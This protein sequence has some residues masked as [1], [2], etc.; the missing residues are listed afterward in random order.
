MILFKCACGAGYSVDDDMAGQQATCASCGT[1]MSTPDCSDADLLL[2]YKE[3][4]D[5]AGV[6]MSREQVQA[7]VAAGVFDG[8]EQTMQNDAWVPI[9]TVLGQ[10]VP[11]PV[12][13]PVPETVENV[14]P[15]PSVPSPSLTED[16]TAPAWARSTEGQPVVA[17]PDKDDEH[18]DKPK[19]SLRR[20]TT[21]KDD[22]AAPDSGPEI[23]PGDSPVADTGP[24]PANDT[25][26]EE[27]K[28]H[29]PLF[30][31]IQI[32]I[33]LLILFVGYKYGFGPLISHAR[34]RSTL[35]VVQN[36]ENTEYQAKLGWRRLKQQL[37]ANAVCK[38]DLAVGMSETHTLTL[39]PQ[40]GPNGGEATAEVV[41]VRV[42]LRPNCQILVNVRQKGNYAIYRPESVAKENAR[43]AALKLN[44]EI[45]KGKRPRSTRAA[46][47]RLQE[48]G[49]KAVE[50]FSNDLLFDG[51]KY[52][53]FRMYGMMRKANDKEDTS[54]PLLVSAEPYT[55]KGDGCQLNYYHHDP[56]HVTG[57]L[58]LPGGELTLGDDMK[59]TIPAN[60]NASVSRQG[61]H[62]E[63]S[64]SVPNQSV[65]AEGIK[66]VGTWTYR[67]SSPGDDK[68]TA[69]WSYAATNP[70]ASGQPTL[71]VTVSHKGEVTKKVTRKVTK[72]VTE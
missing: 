55:L 63:V 18:R 39:T 71:N 16:T 66:F 57:S 35:V 69:T 3:G 7:L 26:D 62:L 13:T 50:G 10:A 9:S 49:K 38:F 37:P 6:V 41:K 20:A 43:S 14:E 1:V 27:G 46:T 28:K 4:E 32:V 33:A 5:E 24:G 34:G 54:K 17:P 19:L 56:E 15:E 70:R 60:C 42:P 29:S 30:Y 8:S 47:D 51:D 45:L 64:V 61:E 2:V 40:A 65:E 58:G 23:Q 59:L 12:P 21:D 48:I 22:D 11:E 25:E 52:R 68:W 72:K 31:G 53:F 36:H 44:S 67:A